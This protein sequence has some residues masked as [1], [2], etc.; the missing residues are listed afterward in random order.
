MK[1]MQC[2]FPEMLLMTEFTYYNRLVCLSL[3]FYPQCSSN[4]LTMIRLA[5]ST[6]L[7]FHLYFWTLDIFFLS[8]LLRLSS[9]AAILPSTPLKCDIYSDVCASWQS[10][11]SLTV[12]VNQNKMSWSCLALPRKKQN[13][14]R[15]RKLNGILP[16]NYPLNPSVG[17]PNWL[18][19]SWAS[20]S[21]LP[22]QSW[23]WR[24]RS[25]EADVIVGREKSHVCPPLRAKMPVRILSASD[26]CHAGC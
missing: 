12:S 3:L 4:V 7:N 20:L 26:C 5:V 10:S 22:G 17:F 14:W 2:Q 9:K 25:N 13:I 6:S 8:H 1:A 24:S 23:A 18:G 15:I 21:V 11:M 19:Q 16:F